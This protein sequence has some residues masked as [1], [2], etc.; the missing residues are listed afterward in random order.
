MFCCFELLVE[1]VGIC[2]EVSE[3]DGVIGSFLLVIGIGMGVSGWENGMKFWG[4]VL[5]VF[6]LCVVVG[7]CWSGIVCLKLSLW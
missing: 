6:L 2:G 3:E 5:K 4:E 1:E 7:G